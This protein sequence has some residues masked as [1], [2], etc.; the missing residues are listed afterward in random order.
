MTH[1]ISHLHKCEK[2]IVVSRGE[3]VDEGSF[4]DLINRSKILREFAQ[5]T[6]TSSDSKEEYQRQRSSVPTSPDEVS[7]NPL[8]IIDNN[9]Q[10][11]PLQSPPN[12]IEEEKKKLIQKETVQTGSVSSI[13]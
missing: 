11:D 2:I 13:H 3:I 10:Q 6:T 12:Q 5:S 9:L 7:D 8:I 4:D 1:G